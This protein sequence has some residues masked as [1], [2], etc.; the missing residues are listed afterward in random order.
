MSKYPRDVAAQI[1]ALEKE[2]GGPLDD[3]THQFVTVMTE[4]ENKAYEQGVED[5]FLKA[6]DQAAEK[7]KGIITEETPEDDTELQE[8]LM[9]LR[10]QLESDFESDGFTAVLNN[11]APMPSDCSWGE[12][13]YCMTREA[14]VVGGCYMLWNHIQKEKEEEPV[15]AGN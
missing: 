7:E 6:F 15:N 11:L 2:K 8:A 5:G 9:E 3:I 10:A 1:A 13:L 12:K 4:L 14:F